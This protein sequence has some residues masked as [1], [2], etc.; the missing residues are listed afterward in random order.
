M[1]CRLI[2]EGERFL[3]EAACD[4]LAPATADQT[5]VWGDIAAGRGLRP[6]RV[7][8]TDRRG[9]RLVATLFERRLPPP[10]GGSYLECPR[11]PVLEA[12]DWDAL[13]VFLT[14]MHEV[15]AREGALCLRLDPDIPLTRDSASTL[16]SFGLVPHG[17]RGG[18]H[19]ARIP[20]GAS[21]DETF[22]LFR[23]K[24]RYN[25]RLAY[26]RGVRVVAGEER[27]LPDFTNLVEVTARRHRRVPPSSDDIR[28]LYDAFVARGH[29]MLLLAFR[30][31][32]LLAGALIVETGPRVSWLVGASASEGREHMAPYLVQWEAI[33]WAHRLGAEVY[34]LL[35]V[36]PPDEAADGLWG[37]KAKFGSERI[38]LVG[39]WDLPI[40]PLYQ[41]WRQ[42]EP[43][44][45]WARRRSRPA[46]TVP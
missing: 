13:A 31:G 18:R 11:G 3:Y 9:P 39:R 5:W 45:S 23:P 40:R 6:I 10:F 17:G 36:G 15:G 20:L 42:T 22:R 27:D 8:V 26:R 37:F 30:E 32:A 25:V 4:V 43:A 1:E 41:I 21:P 2:P 16:R 24:G 14:R 35:E 29:G 34:D 38:T 19:V 7:A 28:S 12:G 44:L 46:L 33:H